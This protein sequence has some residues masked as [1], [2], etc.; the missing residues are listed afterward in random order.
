MTSPEHLFSTFPEF[1]EL[2][3][4]CRDKYNAI[5]KQF[6]AIA[7]ISFASLMTWW[8]SL[9]NCRVAELNGN[10][11]ICY[12]LPGDEK[13]SGISLVGVNDIDQS[14]C[15]IFDY[16]KSENKICRLVHVPEFVLSNINFPDMFVC[17]A[18]SDY[19]EVVLSNDLLADINKGP[20][21]VKKKIASFLKS[22]HGQIVDLRPIDLSNSKNQQLII[23]KYF[24][25]KYKKH[26]M[27]VNELPKHAEAAF[28]R[29]VENAELLN[30]HT[31]CQF[32]D[33]EMHSFTLF[34]VPIDS[35]HVILRYS[36][37]SCE[38]PGLYEYTCF[39]LAQRFKA[40]GIKKAVMA[41]HMGDPRFLTNRISLNPS[42]IFNKY[43][44]QPKN[45]SH[46]EYPI[47]STQNKT[48]S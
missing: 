43:E 18:E 10:L 7:E 8:S 44:I 23:E 48:L 46:I 31:V 36:G 37:F 12:W 11:V 20:N 16:M 34:E 2:T 45:S 19:R 35:D 30:Q 26:P 41:I 15:E 40:D 28:I 39:K 24:K 32:I 21:F 22:T 25:W 42:A 27:V 4:G 9:S 6:P 5:V 3:L 13:N 38:I 1:T 17:H 47:A 14:I 33:D 29:T